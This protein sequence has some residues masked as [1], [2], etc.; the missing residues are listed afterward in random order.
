M[1]GNCLD[2]L[3]CAGK[4]EG[5]NKAYTVKAVVAR[6][7]KPNPCSHMDPELQPKPHLSNRRLFRGRQPWSQQDR[8]WDFWS[9]LDQR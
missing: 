1:T 8:T 9:H 4:K 6:S 7:C 2:G 5:A 3:E